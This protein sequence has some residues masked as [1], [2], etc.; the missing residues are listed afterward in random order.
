MVDVR[1][2]RPHLFLPRMFRRRAGRADRSVSPQS[3]LLPF[4]CGA[5]RAL[6]RAQVLRSANALLFLQRQRIRALLLRA[7]LVARASVDM[8]VAAG[9]R[10]DTG[11][12]CL[13]PAD[14]R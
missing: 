5:A 9:R 6:V 8:A 2:A 7:S 4:S 1:A 11:Q 10:A 13:A 12:R 3:A 14:E